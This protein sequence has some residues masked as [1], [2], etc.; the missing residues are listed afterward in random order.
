MPLLGTDCPDATL[1]GTDKKSVSL[2]EVRAG[3]GLIIAFYPAAFSGLC[4][5]EM[6]VFQGHLARLNEANT[7]VVGISP[8]SPF[9]NRKFAEV[10]ELAFPLLSD[11]HLDAARAFGVLF[12]NFAHIEGYTACNRAVFVVDASGKVVYEWVGEH[13]G[14]LPDYDAVLAAAS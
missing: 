14:M 11:L 1:I 4:D 8:D 2:S 10:H 3:G 13:P 6:C 5:Q 7:Q 12:E 9:A